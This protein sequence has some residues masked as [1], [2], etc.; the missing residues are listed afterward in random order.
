MTRLSDAQLWDK[1]PAMQAQGPRPKERKKM[2]REESIM[3]I[4][5]VRWWALN[6]RVFGVPELA[7]FSIPNGGWRG[8]VTGSILK[9]EGAR[10]GAPD[11]FL[12]SPAAHWGPDDADSM[13]K[14]MTTRHGLFLELKRREGVLSP[15]QEVYHEILRKQGYQVNVC[16]SLAE[17][18]D[19]TT[20]YLT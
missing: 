8:V 12:A 3:Q 1:S 17:C 20:T 7:L 2:S 10:K 4:A 11:L 14:I 5:F 18:I 19:V 16:R 9:A 13:N 6:C 15:E